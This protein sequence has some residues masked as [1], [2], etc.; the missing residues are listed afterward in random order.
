VL[1][2]CGLAMFANRFAGSAAAWSGLLMIVL[3]AALFVPQFFLA[4]N[5]GDRV[6]AINFVF[7]TLLFGGTMLI[8]GAATRLRSDGPRN[9]RVAPRAARS[10]VAVP[11]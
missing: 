3:T 7:D 6:I 10:K 4:Q 11:V 5:P 9:D 2:V 8:I 1:I